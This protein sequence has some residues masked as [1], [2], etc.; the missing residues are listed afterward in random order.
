MCRWP[1]RAPPVIVYAVANIDPIL[2]TFGKI[3]NFRDPNLGTFKF[4]KFVRLNEEHFTFHLQYK[5]SGML[6]NHKYEEL[7]YPPK[8]KNMRPHYSQSSC[9]NAAPSSGT[10]PLASYKEDPPPRESDVSD[11]HHRVMDVEM[12]T[13]TLLVF[14][15]NGGMGFECQNFLR[16]VANKL[17]TKNNELY[18]SVTSWL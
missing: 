4:N 3:C 8:S 9:E 11:S 6:A 1:L 17:S 14:G 5:R 2:V 16:T 7:F 12:G 18:A 10:S 13:F 15:M